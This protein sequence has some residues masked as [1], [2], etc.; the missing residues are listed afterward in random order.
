MVAHFC[1]LHSVALKISC[2]GP[3]FGLFWTFLDHFVPFW[4][5]LDHL[6]SPVI[7]LDQL[8]AHI[9]SIIAMK[10]VFIN[11][12]AAKTHC[13]LRWGGFTMAH[14]L[15][16]LLSLPMSSARGETFLCATSETQCLKSFIYMYITIPEELEPLPVFVFVCRQKEQCTKTL[17]NTLKH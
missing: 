12:N 7:M 9:K 4:N 2:Y 11:I 10:H 1:H 14:M 8:P 13:S 3:I 17:K 6:G 16:R 5:T 15:G